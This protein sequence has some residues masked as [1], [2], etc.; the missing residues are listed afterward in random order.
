MPAPT[1]LNSRIALAKAWA[2]AD[3]GMYAGGYRPGGE[4]FTH[5][6]NPEGTPAIRPRF[7]GTLE[8]IAGMM[9][10]LNETELVEVTTYY[11]W[12]L[13]WSSTFQIWDFYGE[14]EINGER[15]VQFQSSKQQGPGVAIGEAW[16]SV[17]GKEAADA[18]TE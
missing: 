4:G 13:R 15:R 1:D 9:R 14:D 2:W 11:D 7:T 18:S 6:R 3:V 8:G 10:E 12:S 17:F 16:M 5:W